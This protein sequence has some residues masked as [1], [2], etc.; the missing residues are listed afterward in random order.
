MNS[1]GKA[2]GEKANQHQK[3]LRVSVQHVTAPDAIDERLRR[4][5]DLLLRAAVRDTSQSE[6]S[7]NSLTQHQCKRKNRNENKRD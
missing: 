6:E 5:M 1:H 3:C 4:A 2:D 7:Q